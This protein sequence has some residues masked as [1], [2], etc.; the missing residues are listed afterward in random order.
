MIVVVVLVSERAWARES[1]T[2]QPDL[3]TYQGQKDSAVFRSPVSRQKHNP[4]RLC[5]GVHD[6]FRLSRRKMPGRG[7]RAG[8]PAFLT[9]SFERST[10]GGNGTNFAPHLTQ[11]LLPIFSVSHAIFIPMIRVIRQKNVGLMRHST[12]IG[13]FRFHFK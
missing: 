4:E 12:A 11:N 5:L 6:F 3:T 8:L 2:L 7:I 10:A 13:S 1:A 9:L